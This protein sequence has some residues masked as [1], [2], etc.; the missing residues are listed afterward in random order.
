MMNLN[1]EQ[2]VFLRDMLLP[3]IEQ[4]R[5]ATRRVLAA[6]PDERSDYRPDPK[7][8]TARD[9]AWHI[10]ATELDFFKGIADGAFGSTEEA[11]NPT[12]SIAGMLEL[13]DREFSA[14]AGRVRE[15]TGEQLVSP[16]NFFEVF[17]LPAVMYLTFLNNHTIHHRGQ[18][19][20][21]LRAMG[22]RVPAVYGPS[23]D[24]MWSGGSESED[25][26]AAS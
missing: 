8:R 6:V 25:C 12:S 2:A 16:V 23:G 10:V 21:Y 1:V 17:N 5:E 20:A 26:A 14:G 15:L 24:E 22:S 9:L 3:A 11:P 13:Y 4:E 19:T 7:S 18:L